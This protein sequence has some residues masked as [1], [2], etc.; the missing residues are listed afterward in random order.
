MRQALN[1]QRTSDVVLY[2]GLVA[3]DYRVDGFSQAAQVVKDLQSCAHL[4][5]ILT[6][7]NTEEMRGGLKKKK[8]SR[9]HAF[10]MQF[11]H[12]VNKI[13]GFSSFTHKRQVIREHRGDSS[14]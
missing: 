12:T 3:P 10:L 4:C 8:T 1:V 9:C 7:K 2:R 13:S 6:E 5:G 14:C 11:F